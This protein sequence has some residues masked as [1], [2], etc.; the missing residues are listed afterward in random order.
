MGPSQSAFRTFNQSAG[1]L[2]RDTRP[3]VSYPQLV[4]PALLALILVLASTACGFDAS[5]D[6]ESG[7]KYSGAFAHWFY[8]TNA[9]SIEAGAIEDALGELGD[10]TGLRLRL[11]ELAMTQTSINAQFSAMHPHP[12][13][14]RYQPKMIEATT[15]FDRA[16]AS[17]REDAPDGPLKAMVVLFRVEEYQLLQAVIS[18]YT[19][20]PNCPKDSD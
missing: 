18:C 5:P 19:Q 7:L 15:H 4:R 14:E 10:E 11:R 12:F 13:W 16:T 6:R 3:S 1:L 9:V 8:Q 2:P 20:T 17:L